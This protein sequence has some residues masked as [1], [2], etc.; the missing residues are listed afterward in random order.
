MTTY[1]P[2]Q[3]R[4]TRPILASAVALGLSLGAGG[5]ARHAQAATAPMPVAAAGYGVSLFAKGIA[6]QLRF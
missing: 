3:R 1:R 4:Y 2:I 5:A 6:Y